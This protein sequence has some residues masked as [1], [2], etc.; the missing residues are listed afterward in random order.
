MKSDRRNFLKTMGT[1]AT[2][3]AFGTAAITAA[4]CTSSVTKKEEDDSPVLFIGEN[5][6]LA[7]T[8]YGKVRGYHVERYL[9]FPWYTIRGRYFRLPTGSCHHRSQNPGQIS[10][11]PY[12]GAIRRHR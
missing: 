9:L 6:A 2:G 5:I 1:G 8:Q 3:L 11:P 10:F 4:G 7:D 12:G